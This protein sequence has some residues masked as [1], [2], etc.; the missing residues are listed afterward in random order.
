MG[1]SP[2]A[3]SLDM[4]LHPASMASVGF[5]DYKTTEWT[6]VFSP[7]GLFCCGHTLLDSGDVVIVGGHQANAGFPVRLRGVGCGVGQGAG[8]GAWLGP[9]LR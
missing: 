1:H 4:F 2:P 5:M 6:H 7:D 8:P 9:C 3:L